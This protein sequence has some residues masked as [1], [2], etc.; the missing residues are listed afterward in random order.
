MLK[1]GRMTLSAIPFLVAASLALATPAAAD[2]GGGG[3]GGS[4]SAY[5]LSK[6][7]AKKKVEQ[8]RPAQEQVAEPIIVS[9]ERFRFLKAERPKATGSSN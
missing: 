6:P 5:D 9:G 1:I 4:H 7:K 2:G 8:S 3:D